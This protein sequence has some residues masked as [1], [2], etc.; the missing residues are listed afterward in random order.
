MRRNLDRRVEAVTPI[1]CEQLKK[2]IN[3]LF[4]VYLS[5]KRNCWEM[6]SDGSF[7]QREVKGEGTCAQ[8]SLINS[9][10]DKDL[11]N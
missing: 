8:E 7:I 11:L 10:G 2:E 3:N 4:K 1:E 9:Y 6:Q 5:A